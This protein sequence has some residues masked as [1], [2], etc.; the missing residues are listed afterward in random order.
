[1]GGFGGTLKRQGYASNTVRFEGDEYLLAALQSL[2]DVICKKYLTLAIGAGLEPVKAALTANTPVGLAGT[3]KA[4]VGS[5]VKFYR[6][7]KGVGT[8][9]GIVG[10]RRDMKAA[11]GRAMHSHLIEHGTEDRFPKNGP[12]LSSYRSGDTPP[13]SWYGPWPM[14]ARRV[15]GVRAMRPLGNAFAATSSQARDIIIREMQAGL[16][17]GIAEASR[18]GL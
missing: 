7:K 9:F 10:Y 11:G 3:L 17:A 8:A 4:S 6:Y 18:E 2:P 16:E 1:M 13:A 5:A 15:A 14:F 12:Y